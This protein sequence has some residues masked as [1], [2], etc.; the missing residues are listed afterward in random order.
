[1]TGNKNQQC[2]PL[3]FIRWR[4]INNDSD[5]HDVLFDKKLQC[6]LMMADEKNDSVTP[7]VLFD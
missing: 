2:N 7:Y 5:I 3:R 4:R 6:Y 1:M